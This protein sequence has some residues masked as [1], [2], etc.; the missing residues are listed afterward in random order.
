MRVIIKGNSAR[1]V[2]TDYCDALGIFD[3]VESKDCQEAANDY[4]WNNWEDDEEDYDEDGEYVGEDP[5]YYV[6]EYDPE[7]HDMHRSGGGS[8]AD[9]FE[10][11]E[12][13]HKDWLMRK[14]EGL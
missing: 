10:R 7:K 6:E 1:Y 12:V 3:D 11:M 4:A 5:D 14:A 8:F 9:E 2:E 13:E